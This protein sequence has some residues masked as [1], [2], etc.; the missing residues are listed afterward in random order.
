MPVGQEIPQ[1]QQQPIPQQPQQPIPPAAYYNPTAVNAAPPMPTAPNMAVPPHHPPHVPPTVIAAA[2]PVPAVNGTVHPEE[3]LPPVM[4]GNFNINTIPLN[5]HI[6]RPSV[7]DNNIFAPGGK[8][9]Q[10]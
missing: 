2:A 7:N 6:S 4:P 3:V 8:Y 1:P 9:M 5:L 10:Q